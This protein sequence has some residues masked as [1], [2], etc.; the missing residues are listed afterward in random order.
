MSEK[1]VRK[2]KNEWEGRGMR[3]ETE[4]EGRKRKE[5]KNRYI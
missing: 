1:K 4:E 2:K 5:D 3:R